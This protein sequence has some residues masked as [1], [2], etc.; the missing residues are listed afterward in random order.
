[1]KKAHVYFGLGIG[2]LILAGYLLKDMKLYEDF[3]LARK[4]ADQA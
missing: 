1:M 2:I 4:R 3:R